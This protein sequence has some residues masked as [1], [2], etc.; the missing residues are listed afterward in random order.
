MKKM[1]I[2]QSKLPTVKSYVDCRIDKLQQQIDDIKPK[3]QKY[4]Y[5]EPGIWFAIILTGV[6]IYLVYVFYMA[7]QGFEIDLPQWLVDLIRG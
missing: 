4:W 1:I 6:V 5:T 3:P 2:P 7:E